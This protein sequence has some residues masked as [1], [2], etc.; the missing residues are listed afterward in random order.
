MCVEGGQLITK[1]LL[2][3]SCVMP[4]LYMTLENKH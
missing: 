3:A 1:R 2:N 4:P